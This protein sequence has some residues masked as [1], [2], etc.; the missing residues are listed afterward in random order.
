V[1]SPK[2]YIRD[3][4]GL[5]YLLGISAERERL[6]SPKRG[7]GW[8]GMMIEQVAAT[9]QLR[10]SG[11]RVYFYRTHAGRRST[12]SWTAKAS[13]TKASGCIMGRQ[14]IL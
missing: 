14:I 10:K 2:V 12:S 7:N 1:K 5:H 4:G 8:E 9:E 13:F 11:S 6:E 3:P